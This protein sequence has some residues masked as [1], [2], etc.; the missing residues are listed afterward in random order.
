MDFR[1]VSGRHTRKSRPKR[2]FN[3]NSI[4]RHTLQ[5]DKATFTESI[6]YGKSSGYLNDNQTTGTAKRQAGATIAELTAKLKWYE[7]QFRLA[8]QKRIGA[9]SEKTSHD[10]LELNLSNEAEVLARAAEGASN[11]RAPKIDRQARSGS[12]TFAD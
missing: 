1:L 6:R 10:Q 11:L 12:G 3:S 5:Q 9:S 2:S 7:E 8:Q 4:Y